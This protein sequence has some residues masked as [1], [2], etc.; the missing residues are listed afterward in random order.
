MVV[1]YSS[2]PV[3]SVIREGR[4]GWFTFEMDTQQT[5]SEDYLVQPENI[6]MEYFIYVALK[7]FVK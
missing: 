4:V 1:R 3:I 2:A 6:K 7:M 5:L